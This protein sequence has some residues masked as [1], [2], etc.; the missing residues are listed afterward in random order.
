MEWKSSSTSSAG[1]LV[2]ARTWWCCRH[3]QGSE[4]A[5][6]WPHG[7]NQGLKGLILR[8]VLKA[9]GKLMTPACSF[10][11]LLL[12]LWLLSYK[13]GHASDG[14]HAGRLILHSSPS[15][16]KGQVGLVAYLSGKHLMISKPS[17]DMCLAIFTEKLL[18]VWTVLF[19]SESPI[20]SNGAA[21]S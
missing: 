3:R 21:D 15:S 18:S 8:R 19:T 5:W 10:I 17:K 6:R 20:P 12:P 4:N 14:S 9:K 16:W 11:K 13:A 1:I 7:E 2:S